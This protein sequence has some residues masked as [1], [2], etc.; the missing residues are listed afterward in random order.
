MYSIW[1][2]ARIDNSQF[3]VLGGVAA[4]IAYTLGVAPWIVRLVFALSAVCFFGASV[5]IYIIL[6]LILPKIMVDPFIYQERVYRHNQDNEVNQVNQ[7]TTEAGTQPVVRTPDVII[8]PAPAKENHFSENPSHKI[9][10][11]DTIEDVVIKDTPK[12]KD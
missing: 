2:L 11:L 1:N 3:K 12:F 4:G 10:G 9:E 8:T 6:W 5:L 7:W